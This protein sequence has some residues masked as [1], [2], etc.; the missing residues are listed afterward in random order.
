VALPR[1]LAYCWSV[2]PRLLAL[3][4]AAWPL[5]APA[6]DEETFS[7]SPPREHFRLTGWGGGLLNLQGSRP[8]AGFYGGQLTWSFSF[9]DL[10]VLA[11]AYS[12][13]RS[14]SQRDWTPVLLLRIEQSF[15][16]RRGLEAVLA[17]GVGAAHTGRAN[18]WQAWYQFAIGLRLGL[19]PLFLAAEAGFEQLDLFR[20]GAGI[21]VRL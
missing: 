9:I 8:G 17:I 11:Q 21:G 1:P 4:L 14:R 12:L 7:E 18:D 5:A 15:E 20:L 13:D 16:T 6:Q 3:A 2:P 10:G 19:G